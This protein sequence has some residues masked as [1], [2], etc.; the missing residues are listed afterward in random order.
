MGEK[1]IIPLYVSFGKQSILTNDHR[2][3]SQSS[4]SLP[5]TDVN[6]SMKWDPLITVQAKIGIVCVNPTIMVH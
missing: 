6:R 2:N 1:S 3:K 5:G 4:P